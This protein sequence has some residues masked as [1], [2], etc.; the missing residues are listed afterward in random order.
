M[1]GNAIFDFTGRRGYRHLYRLWCQLAQFL[2][3]DSKGN[4]DDILLAARA[5]PLTQKHPYFGAGIGVW[6]SYCRRAL[7]N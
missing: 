4:S 5:L 6:Q 7:C 1:A 3:P 2:M